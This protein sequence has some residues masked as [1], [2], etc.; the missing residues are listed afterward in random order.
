MKKNNTLMYVGLAAIA[1]LILSGGK[2]SSES[3]F[4]PVGGIKT[5]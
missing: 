4:K 3:K 1:L 2:T 5:R